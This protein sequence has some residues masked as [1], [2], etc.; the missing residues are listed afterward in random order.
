MM[1]LMAK[2]TFV[3]AIGII[4]GTL[5][6]VVVIVHTLRAVLHLSWVIARFANDTSLH[7]SVSVSGGH[8]TVPV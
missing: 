2:G 7:E 3:L 1:H 5:K 4:P 6:L 8:G